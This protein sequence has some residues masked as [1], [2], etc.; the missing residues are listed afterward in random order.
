MYRAKKND[1]SRPSNPFSL[2]HRSKNSFSDKRFFMIVILSFSFLTVKER[3]DCRVHASEAQKWMARKA[4]SYLFFDGRWF[5][6]FLFLDRGDLIRWQRINRLALMTS[7]LR[8]WHCQDG[9][10]DKI[11]VCPSKSAW[12]RIRN[13]ES[14]ET[15]L[16]SG[17][18]WSPRGDWQPKLSLNPSWTQFGWL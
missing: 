18:I 14:R 4:L 8:K 1:L 3:G 13:T 12:S 5:A 6:N 9:H 16:G 2:Q 17:G 10:P 15:T 7:Y 11:I